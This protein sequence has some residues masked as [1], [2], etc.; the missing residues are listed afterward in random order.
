LKPSE[1][2]GRNLAQYTSAGAVLARNGKKRT[3]KE[4]FIIIIVII[5]IVIIKD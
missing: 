1:D 4:F 3:K 5:I 2:F